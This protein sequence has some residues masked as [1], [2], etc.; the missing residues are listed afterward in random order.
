[1]DSQE[2]FDCW[3]IVEVFGHQKYAG[4]V[5]EQAVGGCNFVRVDVP[6]FEDHPAFTKMLGQASIFS[7]TPVTEDIARGIAKQ[8]RNKPVSVYDL[9]GATNQRQLS[10]SAALGGDEDRDDCEDDCHD[11]N[12]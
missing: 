10:V 8:L 5:T 3:C 7:M 9:P 12:Y 2:K 11:G 1:M 6:A 4:R